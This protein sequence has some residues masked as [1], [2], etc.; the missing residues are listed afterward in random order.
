MEWFIFS[1]I[2]AIA[3]GTVGVITKKILGHEHA[4]EFNAARGF[5]S[6]IFSLF[7]I[8]F[9]DLNIAWMSILMVYGVSLLF[10]VAVTQSM[11]SLRRGD[12][13]EVIPLTNITPVILMI[14]ATIFLKETHSIIQ[15]IG[16]L[17]VIIGTYVL[18]I[19]ASGRGLLDPIKN[20]L[21]SKPA[22]YMLIAASILAITTTLDK[23]LISTRMNFITYLFFINIF[24]SINLIIYDVVKYGKKDFIKDILKDFKLLSLDAFL[25]FI[26]NLFYFMAVSIPKA[27]ISLIIPLKRTST[28]FAV[29]FGGSLFHEKNLLVKVFGCII[30]IWGTIFIL[31]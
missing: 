23:Y 26:S 31:L 7:L 1:F 30:M 27:P 5:Y 13:S 12:I 6:I 2:S 21:K 18:Q 28:L 19:G 29:I 15:I 16:V 24:Q 25:L 14:I 8:P 20:L 4:S 11:K 10:S 3:L 9:I 22:H 17:L